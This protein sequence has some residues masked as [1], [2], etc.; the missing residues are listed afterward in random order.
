[1]K[2]AP[3]IL[4]ADLADLAGEISRIESADFV[5]V[6]VMD[7]SYVPNITF[8]QGMVRTLG[9]LTDKPL[10]VHLMIERPEH[11][12]ESFIEAGASIITVHPDSTRH[13]HRQ[14]GRIKELGGLAGVALNPSDPSVM[15]EN[16]LDLADLILIMTV[17]P[18]FGGQDFIEGQTTK[19]A[20]VA[21]MVA[22]SSR[23]IMI[24]VDGGINAKT[25]ERVRRAGAD[26][27]VAGTYVF[28]AEDAESAI[29]SLRG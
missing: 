17:N 14:L 15:I 1:M 9:R 12:L 25:A 4:S 6:D 29:R 18:G 20:E 11:H 16:V 19:I 5:H 13:L 23:E 24:E 26:V 7:G 21:E 27:L 3:S 2:I 28:K 22:A 10:D 8:G